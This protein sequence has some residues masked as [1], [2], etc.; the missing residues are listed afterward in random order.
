M[1]KNNFNRFPHKYKV[2]DLLDY[3]DYPVVVKELLPTK[4]EYS[5]AYYVV[6][7][8]VGTEDER[9]E[10]YLKPWL[11]EQQRA[12]NQEFFAKHAPEVAGTQDTITE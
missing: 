12:A 1:D 4:G 3:H 9:G 11:T 2:G 5:Y 7:T 10:I 6:V 8:Q